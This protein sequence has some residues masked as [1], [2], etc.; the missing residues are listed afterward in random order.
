MSDEQLFHNKFEIPLTVVKTD[1]VFDNIRHDDANSPFLDA[2][3][4]KTVYLPVYR[5]DGTSGRPFWYDFP[6]EQYYDLIKKIQGYKPVVVTCPNGSREV[7][8][9]YIDLG[10]M[11]FMISEWNDD[12]AQLKKKHKDLK[13]YRSI[14]KNAYNEKV[15]ERFDAIIVPYKKLLHL[16]WLK[17]MSAKVPLIAIINQYCRVRCPN[18]DNHLKKELQNTSNE[19]LKEFSCPSGR[20]FF[21]PRQAVLKMLPYITTFKIVDR[22][23]CPFDYEKYI[24]YYIGREMLNEGNVGTDLIS[25]TNFY[26]CMIIHKLYPHSKLVNHDCQFKCDTCDRK[27]F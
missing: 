11:Q 20:S 25:L 1:E 2:R 18:L 22:L 7:L 19:A 6:R 24:K 16:D 5:E 8:E 10:V 15:D 4:V 21:I 17:E 14:V 3:L 26:D 12:L 23:L 9:K 13:I 27:C